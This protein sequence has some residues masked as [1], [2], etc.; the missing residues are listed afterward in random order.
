MAKFKG[1]DINGILLLDKAIGIS[2]NFALQQVKRLFKANKAGHT[3]S[4]D[5]LATGLLPICLGEATKFSSFLLNADKR[6]SAEITLGIKTSTADAEGEIIAT[7]ST[8]NIS[9][10][11]I[12]N[13]LAKFIGEIQQIPPMYS[14]LKHQGQPLYKLARQGITIERKI[15]DIT[16]YELNLLEFENNIL[17]IDVRCSKGTYIR[18]LA[19]DIGEILGCGGHISALRR[20][21]VGNHT[22][23][24]DFKTLETYSLENLD[25][26][27]L[28]MEIAV[29]N[30][31]LI[32]LS[33]EI[34]HYFCLGQIVETEHSN[35]P[36][37]L[38]QIFNNNKFL[39]IAE[40]L[41]NNKIKP[42]RLLNTG[43]DK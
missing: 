42:K 41:D 12:Q 15:R 33:T 3:G 7:R 9:Y 8:E 24:L 22:N 21:A 2:S 6:Y 37:S 26:L 4:L 28:P 18:T 36:T 43:K 14:A 39:G 13:A 5:N 16:I 35:V 38:V 27:L 32:E 10:Q 23:M 31:P 11:D 1:R 19:E 29:S 34:A 30:L 25:K 20:T 40:I 17:K